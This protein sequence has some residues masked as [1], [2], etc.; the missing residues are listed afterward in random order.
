MHAGH[1]RVLIQLATG[2]GKTH[3]IAAIVAAAVEAQLTV[4]ILA[5]RTRL[6]RQIHERLDAFDIRH[7]VIAAQMPELI[8]TTAAVQIASADTLY[9]RAIVDERMP[10]PSAD[11]VIFDE[12]HLAMG[13]SRQAILAKYPD[14]WLFGFTATPAKLSGRPLGAQFDN[15]VLG[16][17]MPELIR[18]GRLVKPRIFNKPVM[19]KRELKAIAK[20]AKTDDYRNAELGTAMREPKLVGDVIANWLRIA[21]GRSTIVFACNKAHGADLLTEFRSAGVAA[22]LLTDQDDEPAR[23]EAIARLESGTTKVIVNCFLMAYGVD[24]PSVQCVVLARPT[25]SLVL[26]LQMIGRGM[27]SSPGKGDVVVIDHGRIV[28]TLGMPTKDFGWS[29]HDGNVNKA[30]REAQ[31]GSRKEAKEAARECPECSAMWLVSEEG[32]TCRACGWKPAPSARAV[33]AADAD[34]HESAVKVSKPKAGL[35]SHE[36]YKFFCEALSYYRRTYPARWLQNENK[37]RGYAW[38]KT[39]E[40]F[41]LEA[42]KPPS[43]F[44]T[45]PPQH[46]SEETWGWLLSRDIAFN[47][48]RD[49]GDAPRLF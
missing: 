2:G 12:A 41:A 17:S 47:R 24:I 34:L 9:R 40:R 49:R 48:R 39:R 26:Y 35:N 43:R 37:G 33:V 6:V 29:L 1:H 31:S 11:V 28:E 5:T 14:A 23:E 20:D 19:T 44:W 21:N 46:C 38:N 7:G 45:A 3:E 4:L 15:M 36:V 18:M 13:A 32:T 8:N 25:R 22:E 42:D 10:M 16:T 30:A 27:R